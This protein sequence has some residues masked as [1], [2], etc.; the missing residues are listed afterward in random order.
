M[1]S[2]LPDSANFFY[3]VFNIKWRR[4]NFAKG[5]PLNSVLSSGFFKTIF[6]PIDYTL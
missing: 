2:Q 5:D 4:N 6:V 1:D 3:S